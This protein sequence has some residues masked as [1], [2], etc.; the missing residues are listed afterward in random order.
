MQIFKSNTINNLGSE[1]DLENLLIKIIEIVFNKY[2]NELKRDNNEN[3]IGN[4][5][6][7]IQCVRDFITGIVN[8]ITNISRKNYEELKKTN[9]EKIKNYLLNEQVT[10]FNN[11]GIENGVVK[12]FS[13]EDII[14]LLNSDFDKMVKGLSTEYAINNAVNLFIDKISETFLNMFKKEFIGEMKKK[15]GN[16][17]NYFENLIGNKFSPEII[18]VINKLIN[19]LGKYQ[20]KY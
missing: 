6:L 20:E 1:N 12:I 11:S 13:G 15:E 10:K 14:S 2:F 19:D 7:R 8:D 16:L 18:N 3:M 4:I 9:V 17:V 5:N